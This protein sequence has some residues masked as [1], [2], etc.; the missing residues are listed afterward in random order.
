[1]SHKI[2]TPTLAAVAIMLFLGAGCGKA[3]PAPPART[4]APPTV[5]PTIP[6]PPAAPNPLDAVAPIPPPRTAAPEEATPTTGTAPQSVEPETISEPAETEP[7]TIAITAKKWSFDPN[8]I[9]VALGKT[10]ILEVTS[11]D[12]AH[13]LFIPAL[14]VNEQLEPG[15]TTRIVITPKEPGSF[16]MICNVFCG[17]GHSGM[18]GTVI[19]E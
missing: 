3:T 14:D 6:T 12:V 2:S 4:P 8:P 9:H 13:G 17:G 18:R 5:A 15:T 7:V 1:M 16:P 19:V 10:T 11:V